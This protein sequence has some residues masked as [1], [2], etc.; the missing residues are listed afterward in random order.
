MNQHPDAQV[1]VLDYGTPAQIKKR[2]A[3]LQKAFT[4][5][6]V[7]MGKITWVDG[8]DTKGGVYTKFTLVPPGA[9]PPSP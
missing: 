6:K 4:F 7:D 1:Y 8:G 9:T 3:D 5:R 2:R